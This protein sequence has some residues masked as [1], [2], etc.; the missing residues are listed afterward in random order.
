[1]HVLVLFAHPD[2]DSLTAAAARLLADGLTAVGVS[3]EIADLASEG[4]D[5]RFA[6]ADLDVLKGAGPVP[7]DVRREQER[8]ERF[9]TDQ[10][11]ALADRD[12]HLVRFG[13]NVETTCTF[14][15][16]LSPSV[17]AA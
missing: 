11:T 12:V 6:G 13:G 2:P 3:A 16:V 8:V 10:A 1:M 15:G 17:V 14:R 4:F 9:G 5:P 7:P